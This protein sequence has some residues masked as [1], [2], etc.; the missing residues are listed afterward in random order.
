LSSL[1]IC[2]RRPQPWWAA[3]PLLRER[4]NAVPTDFRVPHFSFIFLLD[5]AFQKLLVWRPLK[6][7]SAH[8]NDEL[9]NRACRGNQELTAE[10]RPATT[11]GSRCASSGAP[12]QA[13]TM[14]ER[15]CGERFF[16]SEDFP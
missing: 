1:A 11:H 12:A 5:T 6:A 15:T 3:D 4:I 16:M 7:R 8:F 9:P 2:V 13:L 10:F 14:P